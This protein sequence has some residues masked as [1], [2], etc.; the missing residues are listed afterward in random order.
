MTKRHF[1]FTRENGAKARGAIDPHTKE[2]FTN[3]ESHN[4]KTRRAFIAATVDK[5]NL[6]Y[7]KSTGDFMYPIDWLKKEFFKQQADQRA[8]LDETDR[9]LRR[10]DRQQIA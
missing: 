5:V 2:T 10:L 9:E 8:L 4:Q 3:I 6:T 7:D 1:S